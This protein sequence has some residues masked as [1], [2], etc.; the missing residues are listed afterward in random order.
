MSR[1]NR[2]FTDF[3]LRNCRGQEEIKYIENVLRFLNADC[4]NL[5]RQSCLLQERRTN[6]QT[7]ERIIVLLV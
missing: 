6:D 2:N 7:D 3:G 1:F 5:N 4:L